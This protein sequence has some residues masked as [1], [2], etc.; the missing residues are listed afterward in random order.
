M[1]TR[2]IGPIGRI[3]HGR[4]LISASITYNIGILDA[5]IAETAVGLNVRLATFNETHYRAVS[6]LQ[7][8]QP[9]ERNG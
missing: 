3:V 1:V 7:T 2:C 5:L 8:F 9:Y 6:A 4:S